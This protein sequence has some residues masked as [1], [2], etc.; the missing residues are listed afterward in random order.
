MTISTPPTIDAPADE[1][2]PPP[3]RPAEV[4][5]ATRKSLTSPI[6]SRVV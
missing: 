2:S 1:P 5:K 6:A 3:I 4:A